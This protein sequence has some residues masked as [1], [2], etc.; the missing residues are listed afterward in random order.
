MVQYLSPLAF[1][2]PGNAR[3]GAAF[4]H[5]ASAQLRDIQRA[6]VTGEHRYLRHGLREAT[7]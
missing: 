3:R 7:A 6:V 4:A 5:L 2:L 1:V